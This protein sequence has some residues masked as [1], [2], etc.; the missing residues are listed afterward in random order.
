MPVGGAEESGSAAVD[1]EAAWRKVFVG[2][3]YLTFQTPKIDTSAKCDRSKVMF[4]MEKD[5][6]KSR[7]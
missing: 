6:L 5:V 7:K 1:N 2:K 4:K 3:F